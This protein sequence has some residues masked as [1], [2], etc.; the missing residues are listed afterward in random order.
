MQGKRFT[1]VCR[2][3][4]T[5]MPGVLGHADSADEAVK[6]ARGFTKNGSVDVRIGDNQEEKH[7]DTESFAKQYGVR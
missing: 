4:S 6:M 2:I 5:A 7:Y 1:I 3:V